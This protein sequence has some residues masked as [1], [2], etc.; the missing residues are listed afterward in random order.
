MTLSK[1]TSLTITKNIIK[2][3]TIASLIST[4][5]YAMANEF[6]SLIDD[7]SDA[8][9]NS[10]GITRQFLDDTIAGGKTQTEITIEA[11]KLQIKGEISPPRGQPGWASSVL[12][13][14]AE[15]L[16]QD[17]SQFE[18]IKLLVKVDKG[19]ISLSA[20][21][22]DVTNFDYHSALITVKP[23]G[24]F[25]QV[26]IPFNT[27]KRAWSEQTQLNT[28]TINS[29]SIVAFG[30]QKTAFNYAIDEVSFY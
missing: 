23:D 30:V 19:N 14:N 15:G 29:L 7:F 9:N 17:I 5:N 22:T 8:K 26:N 18:G 16:P 27:M 28:A 4:A 12:L 6:P 24:K 13:L 25:H 20:N 3:F 11:G 1:N 2:A 21:S 10:L